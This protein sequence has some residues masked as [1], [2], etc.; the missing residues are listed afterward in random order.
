MKKILLILA[1]IPAAAFS[2]MDCENFGAVSLSY[3]APR[4][5]AVGYSYFTETGLTAEGGVAYNSG[6]WKK[7][8]AGVANIGAYAMIGWRVFREDYR[9]SVFVYVG[10]EMGSE[11][12]AKPIGAVRVLIPAGNSAFAVDLGNRPRLSY[13]I[14]L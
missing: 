11:S 2:Q 6:V 10:G 14:R 4:G 5:A 1:M 7:D 12:K 8:S 13:L 9:V 3:S